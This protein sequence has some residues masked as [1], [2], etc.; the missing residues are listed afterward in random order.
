MRLLVSN[1]LR[2]KAHLKLRTLGRRT[3]TITGRRTI[4]VNLSAA[5]R[6]RLKKAGIK[7]LRA[8][9]RVTVKPATGAS[10]KRTLRVSIRL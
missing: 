10:V 3:V 9:L 5:Q 6:K 1:A 8:S 2:K 4:A 7:K